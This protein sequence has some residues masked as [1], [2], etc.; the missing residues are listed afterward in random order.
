MGGRSGF[1]RR[2]GGRRGRLAP[3]HE[4][5]GKYETKACATGDHRRSEYYEGPRQDNPGMGRGG[6]EFSGVE[7]FVTSDR[8]IFEYFS[9]YTV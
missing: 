9:I 8:S 2:S 5:Q 1:R 7:K 4:Y 3:G 6:R